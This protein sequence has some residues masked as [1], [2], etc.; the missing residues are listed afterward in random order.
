MATESTG[1]LTLMSQD[2]T[3]ITIS[4]KAARYSQILE[5]LM[6]DLCESET[7]LPIPLDAID[8]ASL[9]IIVEWCEHHAVAPAEPSDDEDSWSSEDSWYKSRRTRIPEWDAEF[10]ASKDKETIF[11][12]LN[13]ANYM[14]VQPL[15]DYAIKTLARNLI[16]MNTEQM[17][18]Y[19]NV[20]NDF[21]PE[22]EEKVRRETAWADV[23]SDF[24]PGEK[25]EVRSETY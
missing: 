24:T 12:I 15:L 2:G 11:D 6:E 8:G 5:D 10:L 20:T 1:T 9:A 17:R 4:R 16:G 14:N 3:K 23:T 21:T 19:L 18:E 25:E 22:E 7:E 13:A